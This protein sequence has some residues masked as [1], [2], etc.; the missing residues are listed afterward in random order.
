MSRWI[1]ALSEVAPAF[2]PFNLRLGIPINDVCFV[3]LKIPGDDDQNVSF[4]YP[5]FFLDF[6]LYSSHPGDSVYTL[7]PDVVGT[8]HQFCKREYLPVSF[9]RKTNPDDFIRLPGV[10]LKSKILRYL[11]SEIDFPV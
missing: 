6:S 5:D 1:I 9:I 8:H 4:P 10:P 3:I 2:Q 11:T 7:H